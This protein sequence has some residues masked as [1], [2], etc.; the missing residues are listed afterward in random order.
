MKKINQKNIIL[1][2]GVTLSLFIILYIAGAF[3]KNKPVIEKKSSED[4][5]V[6]NAIIEL[7]SI[8]DKIKEAEGNNEYYRSET[9]HGLTVV[10]TLMEQIIDIMVAILSQ[11][12]VAEAISRRVVSKQDAD[13]L[14]EYIELLGEEIVKEIE[15]SQFLRCNDGKTENCTY[16]EL[17]KPGITD[18]TR[19]SVAVL[20]N[21]I[22]EIVTKVEE[23]DKMYRITKNTVLTNMPQLGYMDGWSESKIRERVDQAERNFPPK[24]QIT[25]VA[26]AHYKYLGVQ[27]QKELGKSVN[28]VHLTDEEKEEVRHSPFEPRLVEGNN[29]VITKSVPPIPPPT[30]AVNVRVQLYRKEN[31]QEE[32]TAIN[33]YKKK[34]E[35][36]ILDDLETVRSFKLSEGVSLEGLAV[37]KNKKQKRKYET[38]T[39]S[40]PIEIADV[41]KLGIKDSY[42]YKEDWFQLK[43]YVAGKQVSEKIATLPGGKKVGEKI[44]TLPG[45]KKVGEKI[46][47]LPGGKSK[48]V[49]SGIGGI[50]G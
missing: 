2:I 38:I 31:F 29:D 26:V 34:G 32:F 43:I 12:L 10:G 49:G 4:E 9:N 21:K 3:K 11:P 6:A 47:T 17:N 27:L 16:Y 15:K 5:T 20:Y 45:G 8:K 42:K 33:G 30:D 7:E 50:F 14:S 41:H 36:I 48:K 25:K 19:R 22:L 23:Q 39:I 44:V 13:E 35:V 24:D 28:V 40:G 1:M 46:V 37:R 18:S